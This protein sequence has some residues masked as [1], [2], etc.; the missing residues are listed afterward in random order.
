MRRSVESVSFNSLRPDRAMEGVV[1][2]KT[3]GMEAGCL[4]IDGSSGDMS[5]NYDLTNRK[6]PSLTEI[7]D[8]SIARCSSS[9]PG[10]PRL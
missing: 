7:K 1:K 9:Y 5:S 10:T 8:P 3:K 2:K 4:E 6:W